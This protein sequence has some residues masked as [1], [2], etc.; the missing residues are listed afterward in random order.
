MNKQEFLSHLRRGLSGLPQEELEERLT[1]YSEMIDDRMEEGLSEEEAV[2]SIGSVESLI[3]QILLER[4]EEKPKRRHLKGWEIVL[5]LLSIPIWAPLLS[6]VFSVYTGWWSIVVALWAVFG[7]TVGSAVGTGLAS[8]IMVFQGK[9][10]SSLTMLASA[11]LCAGF[12]IF[13]FYASLSLTKG[14]VAVTK[15]AILWVK[16]CFTRKEAAQ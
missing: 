16:R 15:K 14:T 1:F 12:S 3:G 5:L 8:V 9:G 4:S 2:R 6:A 11:V 10:L 13:L 7:G